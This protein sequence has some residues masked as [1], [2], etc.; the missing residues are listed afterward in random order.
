MTPAEEARLRTAID[1][2]RF[3]E[4]ER[5][6]WIM[7]FLVVVFLDLFMVARSATWVGV[8][9]SLGAF[10]LLYGRLRGV[11]L[12]G[13]VRGERG[14]FGPNLMA[15]E[16]RIFTALMFRTVLTGRN[17]LEPRPQHD[18]RRWNQ[19]LGVYDTEEGPS[20]LPPSSSA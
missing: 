13:K 15:R 2:N 16:Q 4:V 1:L 5:I 17:P 7:T 6:C 19:H 11:H 12:S 3:T 9:G 8:V 20:L 10:M 14:L 18:P